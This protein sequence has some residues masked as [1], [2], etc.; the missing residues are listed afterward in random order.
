MTTIENDSIERLALN[1]HCYRNKKNK[2]TRSGHKN[3]DFCEF[4]LYQYLPKLYHKVLN[5]SLRLLR[6]R[7]DF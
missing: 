4:T 1:I 7:D 2:L 3:I 6:L 5:V